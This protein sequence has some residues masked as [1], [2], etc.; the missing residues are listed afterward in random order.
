MVSL[1]I[2]GGRRRAE[3]M[4]GE[5]GREAEVRERERESGGRHNQDESRLLLIFQELQAGTLRSAR[6]SAF[7]THRG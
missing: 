3:G 7:T 2:E 6:E 5:R 1:W 4:S